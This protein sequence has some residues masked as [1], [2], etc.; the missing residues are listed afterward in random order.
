[1][2]FINPEKYGFVLYQSHDRRTLQVK[3]VQVQRDGSVLVQEPQEVSQYDLLPYYRYSL[4]KNRPQII[5][6]QGIYEGLVQSLCLQDA[7]V[8]VQC[9]EGPLKSFWAHDLVFCRKKSFFSSSKKEW[10]F[11]KIH[12]PQDYFPDIR[13]YTRNSGSAGLKKL[14][15]SEPF[16]RL[17]L[18]SG[19][20]PPDHSFS[21][22]EEKTE[23]SPAALDSLSKD[24]QNCIKLE[25]SVWIEKFTMPRK[26][27]LTIA[28]VP[29]GESIHT[30]VPFFLDVKIPGDYPSAGCIPRV[31]VRLPRIADPSWI[32]PSIG[33]DGEIMFP[34]WLRS[35]KEPI[36]P[37][38][39]T[40]KYFIGKRLSL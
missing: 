5:L 37:I 1:M 24:L 4:L 16:P 2:D 29:K 34:E 31:V 38:S 12:L 9:A 8:N 15:G 3:W 23:L 33:F 14:V 28:L 13:F 10:T 27:L 35:V 6:G 30:D 11:K 36:G 22:L 32:H 26:D 7:K 19:G 20:I 40:V 17:F 25:N 18:T 21:R 39:K